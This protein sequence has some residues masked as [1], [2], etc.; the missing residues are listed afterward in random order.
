MGYITCFKSCTRSLTRISNTLL[1]MG[2]HWDL[3]ARWRQR[4][5]RSAVEYSRPY[6]RTSRRA[7]YSVTSQVTRPLSS[8]ALRIPSLTHRHHWH[9]PI[10]LWTSD[11]CTPFVSNW[12]WPLRGQRLWL[13]SK[14]NEEQN[15]YLHFCTALRWLHCYFMKWPTSYLL[16]TE[17]LQ[18]CNDH[19]QGE[20]LHLR[21][22]EDE[23]V[24]QGFH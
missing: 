24:H 8:S 3:P 17:F 23:A 9:Q 12:Y 5:I 4:F 19:L 16:Q 13:H 18:G 21:P 11:N 22:H 14:G 2:T 20:V 15:Y 10:R 6:M 1:A 7:R